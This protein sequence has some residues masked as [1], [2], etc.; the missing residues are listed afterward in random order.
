MQVICVEH[1][2]AAYGNHCSVIY[3]FPLMTQPNLTQPNLTVCRKA[4]VWTPAI[5][6]ERQ[7]STN[8]GTRGN[9]TSMFDICAIQ[10]FC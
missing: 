3:R 6:N 9:I 1:N 2:M 10:C 7:K 4:D 8:I 5:I